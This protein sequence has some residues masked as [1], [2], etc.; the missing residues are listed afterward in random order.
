MIVTV[1][2]ATPVTVPLETVALV[3]SLDSQVTV[4]PLGIELAVNAKVPS[5]STVEAVPLISIT[6]FP[7][8]EPE[9]V[10][11]PM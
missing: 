9:P 1:P 11:K 2:A 7:V 10:P 4:A 3:V 6:A 8:V 5:T